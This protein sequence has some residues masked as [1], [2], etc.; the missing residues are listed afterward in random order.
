MAVR[1]SL[2]KFHGIVIDNRMDKK[3]CGSNSQLLKG[4]KSNQSGQTY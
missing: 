3:S 4:T 2:H 1:M